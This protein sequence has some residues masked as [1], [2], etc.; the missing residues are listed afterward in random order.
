MSVQ[1]LAQRVSTP[2]NRTNGGPPPLESGDQLTR[3]EFERRYALHP[4]IKKAELIEGVVYV[5]SPVRLK[6]HANPHFNVITWLGVYGAATPGVLGGDNAT[7][8]LD[9]ENEPQ[10]DAILYLNPE[11]GGRSQIDSDDY[12]AGPP[13]LV[14][15]IA[16]SSAAYDMNLKRRVYARNG[17]S[18]YVVF[19]VYER[20]T[21][22]FALREHGYEALAPGD[23]G[24]LRSEIFPGL[25][26]DPAAFWA[27]DLLRVLAVAQQ[28]IA[29]PEHTAFIE[30]LT[31]LLDSR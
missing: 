24:I 5:A 2:Q 23:D 6:Q 17:V 31:Q 16:A 13:E 14:V 29:S 25:W 21:S 8:R 7:V 18:E 22:W 26:L 3:V 10:P 1:M 20:Q 9:L 19:Q 4:E 30:T 11:I 15:E 28:G 12:L 27:G